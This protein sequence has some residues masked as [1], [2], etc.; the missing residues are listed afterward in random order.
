LAQ[1]VDRIDDKHENRCTDGRCEEDADEFAG[2][3]L[4]EWRHELARHQASAPAAGACAPRRCAARSAFLS[5]RI[6]RRSAHHSRKPPPRE[7]S[8]ARS[9]RMSSTMPA[10]PK[11]IFAIHMAMNGGRRPWSAKVSPP[12][13]HT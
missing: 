9:V 11:M 2:N 1:V 8:V 6:A 10:T 3:I 5:A 13:R 7:A 12:M 4:V